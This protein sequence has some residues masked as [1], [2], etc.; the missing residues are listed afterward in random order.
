MIPRAVLD[1]MLVLRGLYTARGQSGAL[2]KA[3]AERHFELVTGRAQLEELRRIL[4]TPAVQRLAPDGPLPASEI[5][6]IVAAFAGMAAAVVPGT[7]DVEVVPSDPKDNHL[8]AA[9]LE[10]G[11][12]YVVTDDRKHLLPL[13]VV[14]IAGYQPVQIVH[15]DHF[16]RELGVRRR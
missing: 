3:L 15:A 5:E 12:G 14:R 7:Y 16:L 9:A 13:K 6:E 1:S 8:I 4:A 10:A 2:V 11:A